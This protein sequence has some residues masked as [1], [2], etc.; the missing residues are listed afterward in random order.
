MMEVFLN[1]CSMH[2]QFSNVTAVGESLIGVNHVLMRIDET[3]GAKRVYLSSALY[4]R[5]AV[6][7]QVFSSCLS[8]M[9]QKD[10]RTQF[11][12][13]IRERLDAVDW[14]V[15]R[16]QCDCMYEWV[17]EIVSDTSVAELAERLLQQRTGFLLNFCPSNFPPGKVVVVE[18][19]GG[20][21]IVLDSINGVVDFDSWRGVAAYNPQC[22]RTPLDSETVLR[23]RGRFVRT[24]LLNQGR[25]VYLERKT[26]FYFCVDN[27][28]EHGAHL[29]V[30]NSG[31]EHMGEATLDGVIDESKV[32]GDKRLDD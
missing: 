8:Q 19:E 11:K 23:D 26:G 9:P 20:A 18:K 1:E 6:A 17:N 12:K 21:T 24:K 3:E 2:G 22:G 7:S 29:E 14:N 16:M 30:F 10:A 4:L 13:L 25:H 28:H 32:D 5:P 15:E 31:Y 27:L